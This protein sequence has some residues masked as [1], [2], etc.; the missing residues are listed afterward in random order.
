MNAAGG[1][2]EISGFEQSVRVLGNAKNAY[3]LGQSQI[4]TGGGRTVRLAD[5]ASVKRR[6][7]RAAQPRQV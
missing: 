2:A 3:T 1:R 6:L 5:I 4:S 7:C